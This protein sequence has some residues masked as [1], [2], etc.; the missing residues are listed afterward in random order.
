MRKEKKGV[1]LVHEMSLETK[2]F[3]HVAYWGGPM[4]KGKKAKKGGIK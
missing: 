4:L 1:L 2:V 3:K